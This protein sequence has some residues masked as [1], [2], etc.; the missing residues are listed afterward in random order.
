MTNF[1]IIK[2]MDI[3]TLA[4][5]LSEQDF[6]TPGGKCTTAGSDICR[7]C[8]YNWL[9]SCVESDDKLS[10]VRCNECKYYDGI[11]GVPGH[12]PCSFWKRSFVMSNDFCSNAVKAER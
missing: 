12:A 7:Q 6:C 5:F 3:D 11:H 4:D 10:V 2:S 8:V 9:T 1:E